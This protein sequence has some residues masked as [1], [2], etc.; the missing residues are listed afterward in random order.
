MM[1]DLA[2]KILLHDKTRFVVTVM[3]VAFAVALVFVQVGLFEGL[4]SNASITIERAD[5]DLWV[6]DRNAP[7]V[8]LTSAFPETYVQ[9]VRSVPGVARADNLIVWFVR[10]ALPTGASEDAVVYGL[11]DCSRWR[12]P[13]QVEEG[14]LRDLK[15][16]K[17]VFL[18][19]SARKRFGEYAVGDYREFYGQRL[20]IIG[21]TREALSFTT[22]P[23]A[24]MDYRVTQSMVP[25][26]LRNRAT[27]IL[28]KLSPGADP[29]RACA[30][31]RRRLPH[32]DVWTRD[33][34]AA[35]SR[36]YWTDT[37]GLGLNMLM[38]VVLGCI[39]GVSVVAQTLYTSTVEHLKEFATVKAIGG[40]NKEIYAIIAKQSA[41]AA[42]AGFALGAAMAYLLRPVL[43]SLDLRLS[44]TP[45]LAV[46][47]FLGT[48]ALCL[49]ASALS[50]RKV[51]TLDPA[52]VFRG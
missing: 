20:K 28:V 9:R 2:R 19:D 3:G 7:N 8:D 10:V 6:S 32:N 11:E 30:E 43:A 49:G 26:E 52:M 31:I 18:D 15:R 33:E 45:L 38:T 13:W 25:Q 5:A 44:L 23:I 42:V 24:F 29:E 27:Y 17:Y 50:C 41:I 1:V 34:W 40:G 14:D 16:G 39:V 47:V 37:T 48:L 12:L 35:R 21:R 51:A 4:L 22:M 46:S 36:A